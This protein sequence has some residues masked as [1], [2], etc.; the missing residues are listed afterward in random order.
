MSEEGSA[1]DGA[2]APPGPGPAPRTPGRRLEGRPVQRVHREGHRLSSPLK[3][4]LLLHPTHHG[5]LR[6]QRLRHQALRGPGGLPLHWMRGLGGRRTQG[7]HCLLPGQH[8]QS[9]TASQRFGCHLRHHVSHQPRR[10]AGAPPGPDRL[11]SVRLAGAFV[12]AM[13]RRGVRRPS[14]AVERT[15]WGRLGWGSLPGDAASPGKQA[16]SLQESGGLRC[17]ATGSV[18]W[19]EVP[20]A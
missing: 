14:L 7:L 1:C 20:N 4:P 16:D 18:I 15:S 9:A 6:K 2:L 17:S 8:L 13:P 5:G 3:G 19:K 11:V 10:A 12:L